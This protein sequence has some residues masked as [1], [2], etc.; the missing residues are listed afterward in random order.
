MNI[1]FSKQINILLP[2]IIANY[3]KHPD[4]IPQDSTSLPNKD[5]IIE[6]IHMLR[7]LLFPGYFGE[8][9]II[10]INN[11]FH[12][13]NLLIQ[14]H[15]KLC[16]QICYALKQDIH[17]HTQSELDAKAEAIIYDF[18]SRIPDLRDMLATDVQATYDGD[19]SA[20]NK[21]EIIFSFPGI[22]AVTIHRLAHELYLRSVPLIPRIMSEYAHSITGIDIHPGAII[23]SYFFIDHGT[24]V[25]IGETSEIGDHV[26]LYQGVTLGAI[27][28]KEGQ[29]LHGKKRHPTIQDGVTIYAGASILGGETVIGKGVTIGSNVFITKSVPRGTKVTVKNP[30]LT[31]KGNLPHEFKQD[32][33]PDWVI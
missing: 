23:G 22:F 21:D 15:E 18:L 33:V 25:V 13:G 32:F 12:T 27:S 19:P 26:K 17:S 31:F 3:Q 29:S 24:G 30:E 28:L 4:M 8:Q 1:K 6:I 10:S 16:K 14:I 5:A 9:S 11:N 2:A 20:S 7:E